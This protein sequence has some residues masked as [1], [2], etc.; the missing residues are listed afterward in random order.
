MRYEPH[1][2]ID[3]GTGVTGSNPATGNALEVSGDH[4]IIGDQGYNGRD[5]RV[6]VYKWNAGNLELHQTLSK[7][8][9]LPGNGWFG[10]ALDVSGDWLVVSTTH[11]TGWASP[12]GAEG[13]VECFKR[14]TLTD[15]WQWQQSVIGPDSASTDEFGLC[16]MVS[17]NWM[18]VG[19]PYRD[20]PVSNC[21]KIYFYELV[22]GVWTYRQAFQEDTPT[23][24]NTFGLAVEIDGE[25]AFA[26]TYAG[27]AGNGAMLCY[28]LTAG[29]W[30]LHQ[31]ITLAS[32]ISGGAFGRPMR[33]D[34]NRLVAGC[35]LR[36]SNFGLG[37][38]VVF[39][40][41]NESNQWIQTDIK[42]PPMLLSQSWFPNNLAISGRACHEL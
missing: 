10:Y 14:N 28:R 32:P 15:E 36:G 27:A 31:T 23:A 29:T 8:N 2:T 4:V 18:I 16:V 7:G 24:S 12:S 13:G 40:E 33:C 38:Y 21:G 20:N 19:A 42:S 3:F 1:S 5:G 35:S 17:G 22:N 9:G 30:S 11:Q 41:L 25:W 6:F 37:G 34:G 39:F 26:H